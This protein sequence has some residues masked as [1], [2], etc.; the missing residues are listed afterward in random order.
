[1][2]HYE[3]SIW[4]YPQW[5]WKPP[6]GLSSENSGFTET[7]RGV[8]WCQWDAEHQQP[9][10]WTVLILSAWNSLLYGCIDDPKGIARD[11]PQCPNQVNIT[12]LFFEKQQTNLRTISNS[13]TVDKKSAISLCLLPIIDPSTGH[14]KQPKKARNAPISSLLSDQPWRPRSQSAGWIPKP[15]RLVGSQSLDMS[16]HALTCLDM[17]PKPWVCKMAV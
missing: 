8:H 1:M 5:L 11:M 2:F 15:G 4:W 9:V 17:S 12:C 13:S 10:H 7:C 6:I 16:W 3:P 14:V